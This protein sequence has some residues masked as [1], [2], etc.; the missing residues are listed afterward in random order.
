MILTSKVGIPIHYYSLLRDF[1]LLL[2]NN[3]LPMIRFHN[4]RHTAA[5]LMLNHGIPVIIVSHKL[6]H[7]KCELGLDSK[8]AGQS[9]KKNRRV[10]CDSCNRNKEEF[11]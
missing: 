9:N 10:D 6:G 8:H 5:S 11:E 2:K 3:G 4:L 1:Q 7:A